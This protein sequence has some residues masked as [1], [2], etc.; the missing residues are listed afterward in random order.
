M[1]QP[2]ITALLNPM[3]LIG[4]NSEMF[5]PDSDTMSSSTSVNNQVGCNSDEMLLLTILK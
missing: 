5:R 3:L 1:S 2:K 4:S